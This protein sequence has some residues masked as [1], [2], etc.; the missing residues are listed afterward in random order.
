[1]TARLSGLTVGALTLDPPFDSDVT[2]YTAT[3]T[4]A[5]NTITATPEDSAATVNIKNGDITVDNGSAA[6]W[7][8]GK[9]NVSVTVT[10]QTEQMIYTVEVTK[11]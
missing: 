10:N 5:T 9:N 6:T 1:M 11:T 4:N 7:A 3:T 8:S 2:E